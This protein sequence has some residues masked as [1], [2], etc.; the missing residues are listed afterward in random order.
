MK[1]VDRTKRNYSLNLNGKLMNL[2]CPVVMGIMNITPD[3]FYDGG[4]LKNDVHI[5]KKAEQMLMEGAAILDVGG[6]SSRPDADDVAPEEEKRRVCASIES[7][8]KA[9]PESIISIDTFRSSVADAA[10]NSGAKIINDISAGEMDPKIIEVAVKHH[11]PYIAMHMKGTPQTMRTMTSY[12]DIINDMLDYFQKKIVKFRNAGINDII[13]DPGFGFAKTLEQNYEILGGLDLFQVL[14]VPILVGV[15]RKSMIYKVLK[16][17]AAGALN[18][19]TVVNTICLQ[20]GT[21]ILRVHDVKE[22]VEAINLMQ[23][24]AS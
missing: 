23:I 2:S 22:A 15:S 18:G 8:T 11:S 10:I 9:F 14:D 3:S 6:Y 7:I 21:N 1:S 19:T 20:H 5:L 24:V 12:D 13:I 16:T 4:R 17:D